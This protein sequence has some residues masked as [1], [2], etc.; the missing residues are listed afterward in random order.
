[1]IFINRYFRLLAIHELLQSNLINILDHVDEELGI[2]VRDTTLFWWLVYKLVEDLLA[3]YHERNYW[4]YHLKF[5]YNV[6][7]RGQVDFKRNLLTPSRKSGF[8]TTPLLSKN[9]RILCWRGQSNPHHVQKYVVLRLIIYPLDIPN[10][11]KQL[12][13]HEK[14]LN[15]VSF[16]MVDWIQKIVWA[17][18]IRH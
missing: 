5:I 9:I 14:F 13:Q 6:W 7:K 16:V 15:I 2:F 12:H 17:A 3:G 4:L 18:Q 1:M 8:N 10:L 11:L